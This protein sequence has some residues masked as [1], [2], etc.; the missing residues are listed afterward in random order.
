VAI[1]IIHRIRFIALMARRMFL[2]M[3]LR[4]NEKM[5]SEKNRNRKKTDQPPI[6]DG[7]TRPDQLDESMIAGRIRESGNKTKDKFSSNRAADVNSLENYKDE[8]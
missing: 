4:K 1:F 7:D 2:A 8:K 5:K 6:T 3:I